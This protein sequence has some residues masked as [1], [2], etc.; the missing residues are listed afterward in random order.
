MLQYTMTSIT[1]NGANKALEAGA[2]CR[3]QFGTDWE[4]DLPPISGN[5]RY[6]F[7]FKNY[8]DASFFAL[9]WT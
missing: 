9:K 6:T 4:I 7:K 3:R 5:P 8:L 1:I 2:W